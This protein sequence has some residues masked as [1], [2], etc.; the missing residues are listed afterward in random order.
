METPSK[1]W[2][3]LKR[4]T[5][6]RAQRTAIDPLQPLYAL[7]AILTAIYVGGVGRF[8]F[9]SV[10]DAAF[11]WF[12]AVQVVSTALS[13]VL[14]PILAGSLVVLCFISKKIE[15]LVRECDQPN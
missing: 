2:H 8:T 7:F 11:S 1:N 13:G 15:Q 9:F 12:D 10:Q 5:L 6:E 4:A 3:L 14:L